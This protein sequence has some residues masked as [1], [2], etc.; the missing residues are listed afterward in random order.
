MS[1]F[2]GEFEYTIDN[3]G[4][5]NIHAKFHKNLVDDAQDTFIIMQGQGTCLDVYP[6]DIFKD[7]IFNKINQFSESD[8]AQRYYVSI[9]GAN[10]SDAQLDKQGR[11][12]I[13]QKLLNHAKIAKEILIIGAFNRIEMWNPDLR[14][15]YLEKMKNKESQIDKEL[16]P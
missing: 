9:T 13:P 8:E 7:K 16:L 1:F 3:K 11:I 4:R 2:I 14:K 6:L 15:D 5:V 10:S 12:A